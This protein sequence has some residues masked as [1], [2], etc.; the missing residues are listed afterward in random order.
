LA[1][2]FLREEIVMLKGAEAL[3][4]GIS[5]A[6]IRRENQISIFRIKRYE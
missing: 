3:N 5:S 4:Q 1:F 6:S 2:V